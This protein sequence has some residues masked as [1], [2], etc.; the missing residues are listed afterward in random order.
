MKEQSVKFRGAALGITVMLLI[1]GIFFACQDVHAAAKPF[2][3]TAAPTEPEKPE[4]KD[5]WQADGTYYKDGALQKGIQEIDG[6]LYYLDTVTGVK[7]TDTTAE[8]SG[9]VYRFGTD[10][11]GALYTGLY[12][13]AYYKAGVLGTGLYNGTYYKNGKPGTGLSGG[14]YYKNGKPGTGLYSGKY[15]K[16]GKPGTGIYNKYYYKNGTRGTGLYGAKF[17]KNGKLLTGTYKN[18][19]YKKGII[20]HSK[21]VKIEF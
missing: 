5:G 10:G 1:L 12:S 3:E 4:V 21:N 14:I 13:G 11:A 20:F 17:Y 18:K 7:K 8:Y 19:L 9:K 15:Y 2:D 16:S 6:A